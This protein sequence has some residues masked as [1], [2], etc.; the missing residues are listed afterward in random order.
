MLKTK[1]LYCYN[2]IDLDDSAVELKDDAKKLLYINSDSIHYFYALEN[3]FKD[4]RISAIL[5]TFFNILLYQE[6]DKLESL[7]MHINLIGSRQ[8][9][10]EMLEM[11]DYKNCLQLIKETSSAFLKAAVLMFYLLNYIIKYKDLPAKI[12][13]DEE[14]KPMDFLVKH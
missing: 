7:S 9:F 6:V 4:S 12:T 10:N 5:N 14:S 3:G 2:L 13:L 8:L 11:E 1:K